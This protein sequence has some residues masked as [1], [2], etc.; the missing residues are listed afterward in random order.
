MLDSIINGFSWLV[1][2]FQA[3]FN[4]MVSLFTG[5]V[6]ML[7]MIPQVVTML[8]GSIGYLPRVLSVFAYLTIAISVLY[9]ILGREQGG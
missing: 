4:F 8:Y 5:F 2:T 1:D 9:L 3:W 7:R 6:D